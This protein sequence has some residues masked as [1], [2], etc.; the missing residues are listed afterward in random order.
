MKYQS[1]CFR[2]LQVL[3]VSYIGG[4]CFT[5]V[6]EFPGFARGMSRPFYTPFT[7]KNGCILK[8]CLFCVNILFVRPVFLSQ[9]GG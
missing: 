9:P 7:K 8:A 2:V 1:I 6:F 5:S 4:F 3:F